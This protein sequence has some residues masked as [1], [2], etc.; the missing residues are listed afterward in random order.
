[1]KKMKKIVVLPFLILLLG[2]VLTAR[3]RQLKQSS[4]RKA[5]KTNSST[6]PDCWKKKLNLLVW[7]MHIR[8]K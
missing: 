6:P 7:L 1:M 8:S 4:R 5:P 2:I 3:S